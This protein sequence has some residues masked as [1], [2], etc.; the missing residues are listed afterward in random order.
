[1]V[2]T[3]GFKKILEKDNLERINFD[4]KAMP[5][6]E[7]AVFL[8]ALNQFDKLFLKLDPSWLKLEKNELRRWGV[9]YLLLHDLLHTE[10]QENDLTKLEIFTTIPILTSIKEVTSP[11]NA[12]RLAIA[13]FILGAASLQINHSLPFLISEKII[14]GEFVAIG[15]LDNGIWGIRIKK[16]ILTEVATNVLE[17]AKKGTLQLLVKKYKDFI[18]DFL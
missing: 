1:M 11:E 10:I 5:T 8:A 13:Y 12:D 9:A 14:L 18:F 17:K 3:A 4:L 16:E 15:G 6:E 7:A 2:F